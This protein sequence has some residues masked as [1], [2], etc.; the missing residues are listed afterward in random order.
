MRMRHRDGD[1][2]WMD[3]GLVHGLVRFIQG[4]DMGT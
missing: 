3:G 1:G 4:Q 2:I